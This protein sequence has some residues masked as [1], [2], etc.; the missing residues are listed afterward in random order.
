MKEVWKFVSPPGAL[1][2]M[3]PNEEDSSYDEDGDQSV[4]EEI[5]A[6]IEAT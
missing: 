3:S 2:G 6:N 5:Q 1:P 4:L